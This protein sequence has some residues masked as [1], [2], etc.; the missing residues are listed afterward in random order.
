MPTGSMA[1]FRH[2]T[3]LD[4]SVSSTLLRLWLHDPSWYRACRDRIAALCPELLREVE[5]TFEYRFKRVVLSIGR[6]YFRTRYPLVDEQT[7]SA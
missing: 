1:Q 7:A 3:G 4:R 6:S 5:S 2:N